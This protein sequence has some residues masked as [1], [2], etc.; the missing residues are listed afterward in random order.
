MHARQLGIQ[1]E[2][3]SLEAAVLQMR[4]QEVRL[5]GKSMVLH[6]R[7]LSLG[8]KVLLQGFTVVQTFARRLGERVFRRHGRYAAL[9][10]EVGDLAEL[11]AG[12]VRMESRTS[13][14]V[15]AENADVRASA[16][17]DLDASHIKVG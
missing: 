16:Q 10:E 2:H 7:L 3:A 6:S 4:G 17:L 12:R 8:G 5:E 13:Y 1:A 11:K 9:Q 14:R 15:R